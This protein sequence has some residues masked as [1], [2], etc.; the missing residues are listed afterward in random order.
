M[1]AASLAILCCLIGQGLFPGNP[2]EQSHPATGPYLGFNLMPGPNNGMIN[3]VI[4]SLLP[5]GRKDAQFITR[6]EFI[7]LASGVT[8]SDVNPDKLNL[9]SKYEVEDCGVYRDS[10]FKKTRFECSSLDQLWKLRYRK[11][12]YGGA[13]SLGWTNSSVPSPGQMSILKEY[14]ATGVDDIIY[15]EQAFR[16]LHDMQSYAWQSRYK[17]N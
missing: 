13:D 3:F 11:S 17:S 14:G 16:L 4:V 12:P 9:F 15:G 5:D 10:I 6:S 7:R 1:K 2:Q 8:A